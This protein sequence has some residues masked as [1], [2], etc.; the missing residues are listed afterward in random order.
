MIRRFKKT[1]GDDIYDYSMQSPTSKTP[2]SQKVL[3]SK[4]KIAKR[5]ANKILNLLEKEKK[6]S[7]N[8]WLNIF[9]KFVKRVHNI[10][11]KSI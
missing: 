10:Y 7:E 3:D 11:I 2:L 5:E 9:R 4:R 8:E 6:Q 1:W